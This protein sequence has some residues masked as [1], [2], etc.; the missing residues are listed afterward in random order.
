MK[1]MMS[2]RN[3]A[4]VGAKVFSP[5]SSQKVIKIKI[6]VIKYITTMDVL[7]NMMAI[8]N[9]KVYLKV[10]KRAYP[11]IFHHENNVYMR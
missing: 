2:N 3:W 11:K 8:V 6:L 9:S 5:P 1:N 7:Y 10:A 4:K